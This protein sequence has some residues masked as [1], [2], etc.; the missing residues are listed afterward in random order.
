MCH[1]YKQTFPG[2]AEI[3]GIQGRSGADIDSLGFIIKLL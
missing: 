3:V 1:M 2:N